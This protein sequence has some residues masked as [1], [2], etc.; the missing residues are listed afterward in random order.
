MVA[1]LPNLHLH[2]P[3]HDIQQPKLQ[4]NPKGNLLIGD[5]HHL[6]SVI[7]NKRNDIFQKFSP[8]AAQGLDR[9]TGTKE[10]MTLEVCFEI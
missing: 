8:Q 2:H 5:K 7:F 9:G 3:W 10:M 6:P 1:P 4:I